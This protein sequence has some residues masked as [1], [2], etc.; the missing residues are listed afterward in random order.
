MVRC[1]FRCDKP[2]GTVPAPD[3]AIERLRFIFT[4]PLFERHFKKEESSRA[5]LSQSFQLRIPSTEFQGCM[6][7]E[8]QWDMFPW[9]QEVAANFEIFL[10][11][12]QQ[13][14]GPLLLVLAP[15]PDRDVEH[16]QS[17]VRYFRYAV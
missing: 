11:A 2:K 13:R 7:H 12:I 17:E 16:C 5:K 3:T 4:N 14:R 15:K 10:Y 8:L 9:V 6:L 1:Y